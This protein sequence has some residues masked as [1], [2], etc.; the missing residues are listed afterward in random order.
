MLDDTKLRNDYQGRRLNAAGY[1]G[2]S[3]PIGTVNIYAGVRFEL[4]SADAD[5]KH[6]VT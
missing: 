3:L 6:S 2:L 4:T 5:H 1:A